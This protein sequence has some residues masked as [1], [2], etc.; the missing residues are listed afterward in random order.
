MRV[1]ELPAIESYMVGDYDSP[2]LRYRVVYGDSYGESGGFE[3]W[4]E[5]AATL[6]EWIETHLYQL[7][8]YTGQ[9]HKISRYLKEGK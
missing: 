2:S 3:T 8:V 1:N 9:L 6:Q 4:E 7:A 5:A